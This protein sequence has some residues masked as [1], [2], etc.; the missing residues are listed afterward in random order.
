MKMKIIKIAKKAIKLGFGNFYIL[1][2]TTWND[3]LN[4]Y[5]SGMRMDDSSE[6]KLVLIG[7]IL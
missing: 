3:I 5:K 1:R 2:N 7:N 6:S 4:G